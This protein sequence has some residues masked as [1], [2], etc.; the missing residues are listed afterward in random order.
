M[1]GKTKITIELKPNDVAAIIKKFFKKEKNVEIEDVSF[2]VER[3]Y[4]GPQDEQGSFE[5]KSA[6]CTREDDI[7]I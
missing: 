1:E 7:E 2:D 4:F 3:T 5:F 6:I